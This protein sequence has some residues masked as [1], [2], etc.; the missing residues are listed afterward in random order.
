MNEHNTP[1]PARTAL[2]DSMQPKA[3]EVAGE[4]TGT[5]SPTSQGQQPQVQALPARE[6]SNADA[7]GLAHTAEAADELGRP[8]RTAADER[9]TAGERA[10]AAAERRRAVRDANS[11]RAEANRVRRAADQLSGSTDLS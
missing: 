3:T 6:A 8:H 9:A 2:P 7:V 4:V 11:A 1:R 10:A 5:D